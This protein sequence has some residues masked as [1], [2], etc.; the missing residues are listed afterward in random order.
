MKQI[1]L[2]GSAD[3]YLGLLLLLISGVVIWYISG[4]E[5]G[6]VRRMGSGFFPLALAL[7]LA[8]FG[9]ILAIR[10]VLTRGIGAG[11]ITIRPLLLIL[12]SFVVFALLVDRIGLIFAIFAQISVAHFASDETKIYQSVIFGAVLAVLSAGVFVGL[13]NMPVELLP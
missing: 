3:L 12:L 2:R 4:L 8:G 11:P 13:L 10:G 9:L 1:T 7:I 6:T 5:I